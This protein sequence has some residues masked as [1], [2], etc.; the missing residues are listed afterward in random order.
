MIPVF[1][2]LTNTNIVAGSLETGQRLFER[3]QTKS[4][5][6]ISSLSLWLTE[7]VDASLPLK[8][9]TV[10]RRCVHHERKCGE[11]CYGSCCKTFPPLLVHPA[12]FFR[13]DP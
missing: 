4:I 3:A 13:S 2:S 10:L 8:N 6:L 11:G 12:P 7:E 5:N 9:H 1:I